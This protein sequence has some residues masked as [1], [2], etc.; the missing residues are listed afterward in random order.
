M[1]KMEGMIVVDFEPQDDISGYIDRF[2]RQKEAG[3]EIV[4]PFKHDGMCDEEIRNSLRND[5]PCDNDYTLCSSY[6]KLNQ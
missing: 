6:I 4:C 3:R 2:R 5:I 1:N